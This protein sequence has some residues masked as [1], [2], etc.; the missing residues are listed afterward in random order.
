MQN[1]CIIPLVILLTTSFLQGCTIILPHNP[2]K[3]TQAGKIDAVYYTIS[4]YYLPDRETD[5]GK[6]QEKLEALG[7]IVN[8]FPAG[9]E[10]ENRVKGRQSYIYFKENDFDAM[11]RL[12]R[13]LSDLLREEFNVYRSGPDRLDRDMRIV[14]AGRDK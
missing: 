8:R 6:T 10:L 5:A 7:Y 9:P 1:L 11:V 12:R 2:V 14:L 3:G 4:I 13:E